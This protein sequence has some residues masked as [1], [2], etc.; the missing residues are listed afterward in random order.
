[1]LIPSKGGSVNYLN[2]VGPQI[3]KLR[4]QQGCS[5]AQL[6]VKI[7]LKGWNLSRESLAKIEAK[8]HKVTDTELLYFA[9]VL[10]T[11][12]PDLYPPVNGNGHLRES[13]EK[14]L[15][16]RK[17]PNPPSCSGS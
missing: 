8:L 17:K 5:Q 6:V 4:S 7:Q 2:V 9:D 1:L 10:R 14:L 13:L 12:V 3:R 15:E 16:R 11:S